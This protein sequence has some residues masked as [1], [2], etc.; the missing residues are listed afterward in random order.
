MPRGELLW[1]CLM[2][3]QPADFAGKGLKQFS[4][5]FAATRHWFVSVITFSG[6]GLSNQNY[7]HS[8]SKGLCLFIRDVV[9]LNLY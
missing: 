7:K 8:L 1:A 5:L 4:I 6:T 2:G 3:N 9:L